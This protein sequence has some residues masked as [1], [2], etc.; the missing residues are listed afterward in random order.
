MENDRIRVLLIE[1]NPEHVCL[2]RQMLAEVRNTR[3][4]LEH[5]DRLSKGIECL[6]QGDF[7]VALLD[8]SLPD[9][10]G[11]D[12]FAALHAE[13][14]GTPIVVLTSID[15]EM[16]DRTVQ[17]GAQDYLVKGHVDSSLLGRSIRY[18]IERHQILKDLNH[19]KR[20]WENIFHSISNPTLILDPKHVVI[21][22]NCAAEKVAGKSQDELKGKKCY[23][24]F[25]G[26]SH[27]PDI[28]PMEKMLLS[29]PLEMKAVEVEIPGW[30]Y[31]I[32]CSPVFDKEGRLEKII[33]TA[34]NIAK[35]KQ[36]EEEYKRNC[37][38]LQ[39]VLGETV[40]SLA[41]ALE[42]RDQYTAGHQR[43]VAHLARAIGQ[44]MQLSHK[45]V[46]G[47]RIAGSLHD[48]GKIYIPAEILTKPSRLT[49][50]EFALI[51][52]HS[53]VGYD[54]L[55]NIEFDW[56]IAEAVLQH[57]ERLDGSGYPGGLSSKETILEAKILAVA[58]VVE[59]MS[60]HRPYRPTHGL[61]KALEEIS[62]GR[63]VTFDG[64]IVDIVF[65]LFNE[66]DFT[67]DN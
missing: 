29:H 60:S 15:G 9:S 11:F 45:Q 21:S 33:H 26:M 18:A 30:A 42:K 55:E 56:P 14:P 10:Q 34:T 7:Q 13:A 8:L 17:E 19:W 2:V 63:D 3:F 62:Q 20:D 31:M 46:E 50:L 25:H 59:A 51:K 6:V 37:E 1:D 36:A 48:I 54:I 58:D 28:C 65:K 53:Q 47:I 40:Y 24:I 22:A 44:E 49:S 43:R 41:S 5:V 23:E 66:K 52:T 57:H 38:K 4:D 35:L 32:S 27:P 16:A 64:D 61:E 12:T 39:R 67:F